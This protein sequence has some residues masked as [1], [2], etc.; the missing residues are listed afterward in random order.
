MRLSNRLIIKIGPRHGLQDPL[1][2][3]NEGTSTSR[4]FKIPPE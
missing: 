3:I 1:K 2:V 4:L